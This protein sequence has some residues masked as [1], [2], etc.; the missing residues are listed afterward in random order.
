MRP[1]FLLH[2]HAHMNF[3]V[4]STR[5]AAEGLADALQSVADSV[6]LLSEEVR[7]N[8][9][10]LQDERASSLRV[11]L[12]VLCAALVCVLWSTAVL[13]SR[14]AQ[15]CW[16]AR[17]DSGPGEVKLE[18]VPENDFSDNEEMRSNHDGQLPSTFPDH[19]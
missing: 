4:N 11:L 12:L 17:V 14:I 18:Y 2:V 13:G 16:G 3:A 10:S 1:A 19:R 8:H 9:V 15:T 7:E 5:A 6:A